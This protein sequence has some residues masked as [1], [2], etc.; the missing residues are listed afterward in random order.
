MT[1]AEKWKEM[2]LAERILCPWCLESSF[3]NGCCGACGF[4][5]K[6][7]TNLL[8][9][10][11]GTMLDGKYV[12]ARPLGTPGG[13][14]LTYLGR[15]TKLKIKVAIK[16]YFPQELATRELGTSRLISGNSE[17]RNLFAWGMNKFLEEAKTLARFEH[18]AIVRGRDFF[19]QNGTAY[20]VMDFVDGQSLEEYLVGQSGRISWK[21][22]CGIMQPILDGLREVHA[23]GV[24][25]LD[26]KPANIF[27]T[28]QDRPI[29]L[30]FGMVRQTM[31]ERS[32][33]L[34]V[35]PSSGFT[36][37][38]QYNGC[39]S[40][41]PWTDVY[42][43]AAVLYRMVVGEAPPDA[44]IRM[45]KDK[46]VSV[47]QYAAKLPP[48][49]SSAVD[50]GLA[51][52]IEKRPSDIG[53]FQEKLN[54]HSVG[55]EKGFREAKT[56]TTLLT[57]LRKE[58]NVGKGGRAWVITALV[59]VA[60]MGGIYTWL[61]H[62]RTS[63]LFLMSYLGD[64]RSQLEIGD[65]YSKGD[66][67]GKD[68]M[69]ALTWWK[70]AAE[71]GVAEAQVHLGECYEL[72]ECV[73]KDHTEAVKWYRRA[74][75]Q[76]LGDAQNHLGLS[77]D[78]GNGVPL[79]HEEAVNW[80]RRAAAQGIAAAQYNLGLSYE[81]GEGVEKD[82]EKAM[83][84]YRESAGRGFCKAQNRLG[85]CLY[86]G[87][88]VVQDR[89]EA[90]NWLRKAAEQG[91][92][93]SQY[94]LGICLFFG[95]GVALNSQEAAKWFGKAA[96]RGLASA[97]NMIGVCYSTGDGV[98]QDSREAAKWFRKAAENGHAKAQYNLAICYNAG[99][100]VE[101]NREEAVRWL[102]KA[103]WSGMPEA[104]NLLLKIRNDE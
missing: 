6:S 51:L 19:E 77:Y 53:S 92:G 23:Q 70:K 5:E 43:V 68:Q 87:T 86:Y 52:P 13:F 41:G 66:G 47:R 103:Y 45:E 65:R 93:E 96:E 15:D 71:K 102:E 54:G 26:V 63:L 82:S 104:G 62:D 73:P 60:V 56:V 94:L 74:S 33:T 21:L 78:L 3:L 55:S 11:P 69:Q 40:Q 88:C 36:S 7:E 35:K 18:P 39:G 91:S 84:W 32:R 100:G 61:D 2:S 8:F 49:F 17:D 29:L 72:G 1:N 67:V 57:H 95:R 22:A 50:E 20:L 30:N 28:A 90:V 81:L 16:E 44:R 10:R 25:H 99:D 31:W 79:D 58:G 89:A 34:T 38:E 98:P 27:L 64:A 37:P 83:R 9:L 85:N 75:E 101:R 48:S 80:Y 59:V 97:Q 24:L 4:Q 76:G 42:G 12:V 14:G 46:Y